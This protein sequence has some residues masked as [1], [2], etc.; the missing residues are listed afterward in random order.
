M[1]PEQIGVGVP[2]GAE[3]LIHRVRHWLRQAWMDQVLLQLD[4][5]NAYNCANRK[6]ILEAI[7]QWCPWFLAYAVACY[8]N[9]VDLISG[10]SVNIISEEGVQQGDPC[11]PLFFAVLIAALTKKL[12]GTTGVSSHWFLDDGY[13]IGSRCVID[14]ILPQLEQEARALGLE[15]N[16]AK[17]TVLCPTRENDIPDHMFPG[18]PRASMSGCLGILGS[19]VGDEA[20]SITW[21]EQKVLQPLQL[22][23]KRLESLGDPRAASLILRQCLSACKL[24]YFTRTA[25]G[26]VGLALASRT[27]PLLRATWDTILGT[28]TSDATWQLST[29]PIRLG[30]A[31]ISCPGPTADAAFLSSWFGAVIET[32]GVINQVPAAVTLAVNRLLSTAPALA[33]PL[34]TAL[35]SGNLNALRNSP[36]VGRWKDQSAWTDELFLKQASGFDEGV[37]ARLRYLREANSASGAGLWLT[38]LPDPRIPFS[39]VE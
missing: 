35:H 27:D 14:A 23:L 13:L 2:R 18:I 28:S 6:A 4:F 20:A 36:L 5:R 30:G 19:P 21:G 9:P 38:A 17:C 34:Q 3:T 37:N 8:G 31:G 7:Q 12:S 16:R 33:T 25:D 32:A 11:G 22:A 10:D 1:L 29:L 15:L 26:P 39:A 24:N